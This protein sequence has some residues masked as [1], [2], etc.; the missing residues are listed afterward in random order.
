VVEGFEAAFSGALQADS[1]SSMA[2]IATTAGAA[3]VA[4]LAC[5]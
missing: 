3:L 2:I 1:T 4:E 5:P